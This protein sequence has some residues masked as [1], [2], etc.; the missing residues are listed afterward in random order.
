MQGEQCTVGRD[1][2]DIGDADGYNVGGHDATNEGNDNLDG[3]SYDSSEDYIRGNELD[4]SQFSGHLS[5]PS[6]TLED[7]Q[8]P[9]DD[10]IFKE[11]SEGYVREILRKANV[12]NK[13][14]MKRKR[15]EA[16]EQAAAAANARNHSDRGKFYSDTESRKEEDLNSYR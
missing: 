11:R 7:I 16:K 2:N 12:L 1:G 4:D 3:T 10:D 14:E 9:S 6:W 13:Q 8:G 5:D 15:R